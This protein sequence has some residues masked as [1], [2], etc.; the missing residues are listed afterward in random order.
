MKLC[1]MKK[2]FKHLK[3]LIRFTHLPRSQR[4]LVFYSEGKS[5]WA[6]LEGIVKTLLKTSNIP[7]CYISSNANDPGLA[8]EHSHYQA[9][10]ID[11]GWIRNWL[12]ENID[13]DVM[14]M[15]MPDLHQY[16]VKR[17]RHPVHYIYVQHSFVSLHMV[18]RKGAFDHYDTIF[19][20]GPHHVK[21]IRAMEA[22]YHLPPKKIFEHG[23]SRLDAIIRTASEAPASFKTTSPY[24]HVL[25]APSWG[26]YSIIETI[27]DGLVDHLLKNNFKV[28]LRP[29]PQTLKFAAKKID[30]ILTQHKNNP[31]FTLELNTAD[32]TSLHNSDIMISDWSGAAFDYAF[33]LKKPVLF[34]DVPKKINNPEYEQISIEPIEDFL[35]TTIG[36]V[37]PPHQL[38]EIPNKINQLL[39]NKDIPHAIFEAQK[40]YVFNCLSSDQAASDYIREL[41]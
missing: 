6:H 10:E 1:S 3:N 7:I 33:G 40:K 2:F 39:K 28:T 29:H 32:Q 13:T 5:Y 19:C 9:F 21:E 4:R 27:G 41:L 26:A 34:I 15:T 22:I 31:L 35:R 25:I 12:F 30:A 20:A 37:I 18:Y 23:Y 38:N 24:T 11:E 36:D 16:Q 8:L 14:V 17:S